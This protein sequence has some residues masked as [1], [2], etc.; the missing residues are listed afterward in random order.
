MPHNAPVIPIGRIKIVSDL[1]TKSEL[2]RRLGVSRQRI[3]Q[4]KQLGLLAVESGV[5]PHRHDR[6]LVSYGRTLYNLRR[7]ARAIAKHGDAS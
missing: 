4:Y 1:I 6:R 3:H 5:S 7:R 2:S